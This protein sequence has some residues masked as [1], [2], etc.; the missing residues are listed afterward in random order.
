VLE[1]RVL[2]RI[3]GPKRDEVTGDWRKLHKEELRNLNLSNKYNLNDKVKRNKMDRIY[4]S[5]RK[6]RNVYRCTRQKKMDH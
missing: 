3:F 2:C 4:I 6:K 1:M 5:S